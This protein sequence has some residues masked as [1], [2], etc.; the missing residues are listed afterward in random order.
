MLQ[1][2]IIPV[3]LLKGKGLVKSVKFKET[4]YIGD[5]INAVR[6]FNEKEVD[7]IV[8]IDIEASKKKLEPNIEFLNQ[9]ATEAFVPMAYGGGITTIKQAKDIMFAGFEKVILNNIIY[10]KPD[11][12]KTLSEYIGSS[13]VVVSIDVKKNLWGKY[14]VYSHVESKTLDI[15]P[16]EYMI[17]MQE[18]GAGEILIN[19]VERDGVMQGY[20]TSLLSQAMKSVTIPIIGCG[21]ASSFSDFESVFNETSIPALA[22]GSV[23]VFHGKH[24]AVLITYPTK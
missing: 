18:L 12:I 17:K 16:F 11:F 7:E 10:T 8:I 14:K 6:I 24:K 15:D 5:P 22:A 1:K 19:S 2:R 21:G 9:I 13:S 3:L 23:F 20:D 4:T